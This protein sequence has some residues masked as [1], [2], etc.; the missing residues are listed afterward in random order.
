MGNSVGTLGWVIRNWRIDINGATHWVQLRHYTPTASFQV[1]VDEEEVAAERKL[2]KLESIPF[3]IQGKSGKVTP[4]LNTYSQLT[5]GFSYECTFDGEKIKELVFDKQ[6]PP[7]LKPN[8]KATLLQSALIKRQGDKK[9]VYYKVEVT[10]GDPLNVDKYVLQKRFSDFERLDHLIRSNFSG[11]HL[12]SNLPPKPSKSVKLITDHL[13]K[14]FVNSSDEF[15][16][17][18]ESDEKEKKNDKTNKID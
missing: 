17:Q 14:R 12:Q 18:E 3:T 8:L 10:D 16:V 13:D 7:P 5:K 11:H 4:S 15:K 2:T 6:E 1:F 9:V